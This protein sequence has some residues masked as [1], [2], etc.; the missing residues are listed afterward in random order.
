LADLSPQH[1]AFR[2][3]GEGYLLEALRETYV[4]GR[5]VSR[6]ASLRD[7][8][9]VQ[10]GHGV[11]LV[12]RRPHA[13]SA[14]ARLDFASHHRTQPSVDGILLMADACVLGP[15]AHSHVVCP[16]WPDE[17]VLFR[18]EQGLYCRAA[19][20]FEINGVRCRGRGRL[21]AESRVSGE[22][23]SLGVGG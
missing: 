8:A 3:D 11:K 15:K 19:G 6:M 22:G 14:T 23:W 10:L 9:V 21:A 16:A 5:P 1:A 20:E 13:L 12:F 4:D 17:V 7:G 18:H 2:R